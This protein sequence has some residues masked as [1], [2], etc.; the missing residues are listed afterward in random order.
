MRERI[1]KQSWARSREY[2]A[3]RQMNSCEV[4]TPVQLKQRLEQIEDIYYFTE[5]IFGELLTEISQKDYLFTLADADGYILYQR[6]ATCRLNSICGANWSEKF[7]GT[8]AIGTAIK[9]GQTVAVI[10]EE[11]YRP[12]NRGL[13]CTSSPIF[14]PYTSEIIGVVD[15]S[16]SYKDYSPL[17]TAI[18]NRVSRLIQNKILLQGTIDKLTISLKNAED[19]GGKGRVGLEALF[20]LDETGKIIA[21]NRNASDICDQGLIN[22]PFTSLFTKCNTDIEKIIKDPA[23]H[24]LVVKA[25]LGS[26]PQLK[27]FYLKFIPPKDTKYY[28]NAVYFNRVKHQF[29]KKGQQRDAIIGKNPALTKSKEIALLAAQSDCSILIEAETGTG[30]ELFA[31]LIHRH[32]PRKN[33]PFIAI[34]CAAIPENLVGSEL[35]GYEEGAFTGAKRSGQPGK[36]ELA[37]KGTIF[38][39]EIGDMPLESQKYLLRV[40]EE[41]N[42]TR[43][44]GRKSVAVDV[45]II[46]ATHKSLAEQVLEYAFRGDLLYR[47]NTMTIKIPSLRERK[48]DIIL[49]VEYFL[50]QYNRKYN[51]TVKGLRAEVERIFMAYDWPGNVRELKNVIERAVILTENETIGCDSLPGSLLQEK[52]PVLNEL[53]QEELEAILSLNKYNISKTARE[54]NVARNTLYRRMRLLGI[55][56]ERK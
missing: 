44:G 29:D 53:G 6:G 1:I 41:K 7:Q 55:K 48:E 10:G 37:D 42:I 35:F 14:S 34:N 45:R 19:V 4:L 47:L 32:S 49:L 11:H 18:I 25:A 46:A 31:R 36:F 16:G 38:L 5:P 17:H 51:K 33:G 15:I 3:S 26:S 2:R 52:G 39:D 50:Q 28:G 30:K 22:K 24:E 56:V 54:L 43:I 12:E 8:N 40:L 20:I 27:P 9:T 13:A 23:P 21:H